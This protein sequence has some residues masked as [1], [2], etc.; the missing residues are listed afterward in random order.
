MHST[1]ASQTLPLITD[2]SWKRALSLSERLALFRANDLKSGTFDRDLAAETLAFWKST[3]PFDKDSWFEKRLTLDGL[4]EAEFAQ[5]L[6]AS[7]ESLNATIPE[8]VH[9]LSRAYA[10]TAA[11]PSDRPNW[12]PVASH[13]EA[14]FLRLVDPLLSHA[15]QALHARVEQIKAAHPAAPFDPVSAVQAMYNNLPSRLLMILAKTTV[16]ELHVARLE[17]VLQGETPAERFLSFTSR[18]RNREIALKLLAEYPVMARRLAVCVE[19]WLKVSAEFLEHLAVDWRELID[20]F[21]V[22]PDCGELVEA[23]AGAGDTHRHGRSVV[24]A[25]FK[26]GFQ[27]VY[28]P[29]STAVDLHFQEFLEWTNSKGAF[30]PLRTLKVLDK[31]SHGWVEFVHTAGC[32]SREEVVRF[33]ERQGE[34]MAI[35]YV[36]Q[37]TDFHFE[38]LLACG[39]HPV[40]V[41]LEAL[42]HPWLRQINIQ[43]PDAR[44]V[45][46]AKSRSVLRTG[47]LPRRTG[48]HADYAG[49]ELSGLG[50]AAGQITDNILQWV[51]EGTDEMAAVR[52]PFRMPGAR[53]RPAVEGEEIDVRHYVEPIVHGFTRM[54]ELLR[55]NRDELLS[56]AGPLNRFAHDEVRVVA[57]ATRGY[58]VLLSQSLHPDYLRDAIDLELLLDR[59]W[60]GVEENAH[61]VPLIPAER[62]DLM[63]GDIPIFTTQPASLDLC[64]STGEKIESYLT[65]SGLALSREIAA[66]LNQADLRR[67]IWFIRASIATLDLAED[68]L[69]RERYEPA[70]PER[71]LSRQ[72][73]ALM[74]VEEARRIGD[75]L[76]A[77]ALQETRDATWIGF[78][79]VN[80]TWSLDALFED[81]YT[82]SS[83]IILALAHLGSFGFPKYTGLARRGLKTLRSRMEQRTKVLRSIGAFDG[84]GGIV[85]LL[86]HLGALWHDDDLIAWAETI[87]DRLPELISED[88]ALDVIGGSAGCIGALLALH[89]VA[90]SPKTLAVAMQCGDRLLAKAQFVPGGVGWF[91]NIETAKPITGFAHG[92]AG[93]AWALLELA[94]LTGKD[95]Y[96]ETAL[97]SLAYEHTQYSSVTGN[98]VDNA[99]EKPTTGP[100]MA[101]CYGAPGIGL[102]RVAA[103]RCAAADPSS[104]E[105]LD[106][107]IAATLARGFGANHSLCHGDLGNL[108]FLLQAAQFTRSADLAAKVNELANH[109]LASIRKHGPLCGVPLAVESPALMNGLAGIC[110]GLLRLAAP[111]RVPS[112]LTLEPPV[113]KH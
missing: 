90:P 83:G 10:T 9:L 105:D 52:Q 78:A 85:Y 110:Y 24:I 41:D 101:W 18:L 17:G 49:I 51:G 112:V 43:Q 1:P 109:V 33:Y 108:D 67:Q 59:L 29:R 86:S 113:T 12:G 76:E 47:M 56:E 93:I 77:L 37:A 45:V 84:W 53:N 54:Y 13:P 74:L 106:H 36:L 3:S 22:G 31:K 92:A 50:G 71:M 60:V 8:W 99:G 70:P 27:L 38:N 89:R 82:G 80:K 23:M 81:L 26:S 66:G 63:Q 68:D 15:Q 14:G 75:R 72:E 62:S 11:E 44:M 55:A 57:R 48:V 111:D 88:T 87:V 100:S 65:K 97:Q 58:G 40:L 91:N 104:R 32:N 64:T 35:L 28:K 6:G 95:R 96:R 69:T 61:L 98:W 42:F 73:L 46:L 94:E 16:L 107:A 5:L 20:L 2:Q 7:P 79:Y 34:Y 4:S 103:V 19:H 21:N 25:R 30:P 102:A 39:E